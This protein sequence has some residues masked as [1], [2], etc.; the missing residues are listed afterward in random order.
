MNYEVTVKVEGHPDYTVVIDAPREGLATTRAMA[1][2]PHQLCG[3]LVEFS[4]KELG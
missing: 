2:Y 1:V 3:Q 4:V